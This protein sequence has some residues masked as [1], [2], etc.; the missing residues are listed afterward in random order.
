VFDDVSLLK[1]LRINDDG[2]ISRRGRRIT[3]YDEPKVCSPRLLKETNAAPAS[4]SHYCIAEMPGSQL[5]PVVL[6]I[7]YPTGFTVEN[8]SEGILLARLVAIALPRLLRW[9]IER[10]YFT[11][12]R[13]RRW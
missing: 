9:Y 12:G 6:A 10:L 3:F 5:S 7:V 13:S 11:G 1:L 8:R 4:S 2:F